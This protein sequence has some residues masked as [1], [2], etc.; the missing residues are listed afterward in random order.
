MNNNCIL[1]IKWGCS[2]AVWSRT[3]QYIAVLIQSTPLPLVPVCYP[4]VK[5]R[6][7]ILLEIITFNF[8]LRCSIGRFLFQLRDT[9]VW[10]NQ[11]CLHSYIDSKSDNI[12][13]L[14]QR[15][16]DESHQWRYQLCNLLFNVS[17]LKKWS[18]SMNP[19]RWMILIDV[20]MTVAVIINEWFEWLWP[21]SMENCRYS[22]WRLISFDGAIVSNRWSAAYLTVTSIYSPRIDFRMYGYQTS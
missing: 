1:I 11:S 15:I 13:I 12:S 8:I 18:L 16:F 9:T 22:F 17:R 4:T 19:Y 10:N 2:A 14:S 3:K 21:I 5:A 20:P 6:T 7:A